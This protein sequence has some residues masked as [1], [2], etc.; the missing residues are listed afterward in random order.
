MSS[1]LRTT[2]GTVDD[3]TAKARIR[4]AAIEVFADQGM[5]ATTARK[6]ASAA[7]VSPGLV[8]HHFGS[9]DGLRVACD[10]YV[11]RVIRDLKGGAMAAGAAFDPLGALRSQQ[12]GPPFAKYLARTL[13]D[14]SPHVAELVDELVA[15]AISYIETG[16]ETG[17]LTPSK[18][19][20]QRAAILTV[21]SL[22]GLVLHEHLARLIGI[23]I[24]E[25]LDQPRDA[26]SYVAPVLEILSGFLTETTV[27]MMSEAFVSGEKEES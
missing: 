25:P 18:Y 22:G 20:R 11:T 5:A 16:V 1:S 24:T 27:E 15:D 4:D 17:M 6:V 10:E 21:W 2:E 23:D 3:R 14:E 7:G 9:M 8:M 26:A 19:P 13:V 12:S